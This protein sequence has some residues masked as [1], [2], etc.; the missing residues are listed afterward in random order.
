HFFGVIKRYYHQPH[1]NEHTR[2]I[3]RQKKGSHRSRT[4]T[5]Q[6]KYDQRIT[7][8]DDE[9]GGGRSNVDAYRKTFRVSIF[10]HSVGHNATNSGGSSYCRSGNG[11]KHHGRQNIDKSQT[12][13]Q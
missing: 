12:S 4:P 11:T 8:R 7:R 2:Y 5:R 9:T 10:G 13:R 1:P 6:S 3:P